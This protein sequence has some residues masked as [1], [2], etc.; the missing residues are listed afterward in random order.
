[1]SMK[2]RIANL[3]SWKVFEYFIV[4]LIIFYT[5]IVF[6]NFG[7]DDSNPEDDTPVNETIYILSILELIILIIFTFEILA[8]IYVYTFRVNFFKN[9]F[10]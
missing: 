1:M 6:V 5:L 7:L 3:L 9:M 4:T 10:F 2:K 8:N